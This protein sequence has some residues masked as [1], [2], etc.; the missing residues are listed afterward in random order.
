M[1]DTF[2]RWRELI[3]ADGT[4]RVSL[5]CG[6]CGYDLRRAHMLGRCPECGQPVARSLMRDDP[7]VL[8][9]DQARLILSGLRRITRGAVL[10]ILLPAVAGLNAA[11]EQLS[12]AAGGRFAVPVPGTA[13]A[14]LGVVALVGWIVSVAG[15]ARISAAA[16]FRYRRWLRLLLVGS[17]LAALLLAGA[18]FGGR[19]RALG[20]YPI[21]LAGFVAGM[22]P[23]VAYLRELAV[24]LRRP[25]A[26]SLAGLATLALVA[27]A[28]AWVLTGVQWL[29]SPP[30]Q[31][32]RP[33]LRPSPLTWL[34]AGAGLVLFVTGYALLA[35]CG[36]A[37]GSRLRGLS[38]GKRPD[39]SDAD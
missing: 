38:D 27:C 5:P 9:A 22:L 33:G 32:W 24:R 6:T 13:W 29:I 26:R 30:Y 31:A 14:M 37:L 21:V 19:V 25:S 23:V 15:A 34:P 16:D 36:L 12:T 20:P 3:D 1:D 2:E 28:A 7:L 39:Q 10:V 18:T 17:G 8:P 35:S 11:I 4:L